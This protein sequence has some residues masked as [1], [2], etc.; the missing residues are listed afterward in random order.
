MLLESCDFWCLNFHEYTLVPP[1][2][3]DV[4]RLNNDSSHMAH[5]IAKYFEIH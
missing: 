2:M 1:N 5:T 3:H 4:M